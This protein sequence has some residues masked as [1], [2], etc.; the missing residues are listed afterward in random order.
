MDNN[1]IQ[2]ITIIDKNI[3][4]KILFF[5]SLQNVSIF[6]SRRSFLNKDFLKRKLF[7]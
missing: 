7:T 3:L 1:F 4:F 5:N 2:P 6:T